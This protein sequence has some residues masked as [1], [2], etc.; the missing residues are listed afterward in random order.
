MPPGIGRS[1]LIARKQNRGH[2]ESWTVSELEVTE[3]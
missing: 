1:P 3:A 2:E